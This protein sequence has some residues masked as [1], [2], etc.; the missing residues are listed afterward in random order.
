MKHKITCERKMRGKEA[1]YDGYLSFIREVFFFLRITITGIR[2]RRRHMAM[3]PAA[4]I[5]QLRKNLS[6]TEVKGLIYFL[7]L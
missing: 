7:F 3:A 2:L 4:I 1:D 6:E 5:N